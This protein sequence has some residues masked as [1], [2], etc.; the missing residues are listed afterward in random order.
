MKY[1]VEVESIDEEFEEEIF[2]YEYDNFDDAF[3]ALKSESK[4]H[5]YTAELNYID[6]E[7]VHILMFISGELVHGIFKY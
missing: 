3:E 1:I 5:G 7:G 2:T 4:F 6:E